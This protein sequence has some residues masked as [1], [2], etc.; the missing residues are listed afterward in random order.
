MGPDPKIL[1]ELSG[2]GSQPPRGLKVLH[3]ILVYTRDENH[4]SKPNQLFYS[5]ISDWHRVG[6]VM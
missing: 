4:C 3:V 2:P 5:I 1:N 6:H